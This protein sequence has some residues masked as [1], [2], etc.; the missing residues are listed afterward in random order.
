[1]NMEETNIP[2]QY[3]PKNVETKLY[4]WWT[5]QDLFRPIENTD[6]GAYSIVIPPPNV[7]GNLHMGHALNLSIQDVLIRHKRMQGFD[8]LW[9]PGMDHAGIATRHGRGQAAPRRHFPL[10]PGP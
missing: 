2:K 8:T 4:S 1:M 6:K 5:E 10:R 9:L 7:T 3:D